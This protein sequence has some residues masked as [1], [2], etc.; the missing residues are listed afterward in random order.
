MVFL[1]VLV[2]M[3]QLVQPD[4]H[5]S[6]LD[7]S[8]IHALSRCSAAS[9]T[10][11]LVGGFE[12]VNEEKTSDGGWS[13]GWRRRRLKFTWHSVEKMTDRWPVVV[14]G[15]IMTKKLGNEE[16]QVP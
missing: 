1:R 10:A 2:S 8:W 11:T 6:P 9:V 15:P 4:V 5:T 14:L 12:P 16:T 3:Y 13:T 7:R